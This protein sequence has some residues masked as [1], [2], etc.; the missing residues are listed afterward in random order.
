MTEKRENIDNFNL[1]DD[2][3]VSILNGSESP[4]KNDPEQLE[5]FDIRNALLQEEKYLENKIPS[6]LTED[7]EKRYKIEQESLLNRLKKEGLL[8]S[9]LSNNTEESHSFYRNDSINK[10]LG[11]FHSNSQPEIKNN[12]VKDFFFRNKMMLGSSVFVTL[13]GF[14]VFPS[15]YRYF[16]IDNNLNYSNNGYPVL[17]N[18]FV[19][20]ES[21]TPALDNNNIIKKSMSNDDNEIEY[22]TKKPKELAFKIRKQLESAGFKVDLKIKNKGWSLKTDLFKKN[23]DNNTV[24]Q[25]INKY[26]L[27]EPIGAN[28]LN[29]LFI[30]PNQ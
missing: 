30:S 4:D 10:P 11:I 6:F 20:S 14:F 27:P 16:Y 28:K 29:I 12:R 2:K 17:D 8:N 3:W 26:S 9:D 13:L 24:I 5:V 23:A 21:I 19:S 25:I 22:K 18:N 7:Q 15:L 1:D